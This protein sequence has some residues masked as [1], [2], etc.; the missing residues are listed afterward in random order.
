MADGNFSFGPTD[1][2]KEERLWRADPE[3]GLRPLTELG[4]RT[5]CK[6]PLIINS[7]LLE[8]FET[9]LFQNSN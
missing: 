8:I 9:I 4:N 6:K 3:D 1:A 7:E 5:E 2:E